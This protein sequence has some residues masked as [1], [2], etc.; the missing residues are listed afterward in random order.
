GGEPVTHLRLEIHPDGGVARL[1]AYGQ[2][3]AE[4][5]DVIAARWFNTL[6]DS[7]AREVLAGVTDADAEELLASRPVTAPPDH[8]RA[9]LN[10]R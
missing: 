7:H 1:R 8:L 3:T 10:R 9:A 2:L 5:A 6:P 4:A